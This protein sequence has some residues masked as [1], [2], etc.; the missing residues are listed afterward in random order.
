MMKSELKKT[1]YISGTLCYRDS[2]APWVI[3]HILDELN[4][5]ES[6]GRDE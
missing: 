1:F 2:L 3:S 5:L 6:G 4:K